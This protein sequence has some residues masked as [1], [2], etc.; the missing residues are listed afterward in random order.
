M[1][2]PVWT[3]LIALM[4]LG[5]WGA[6]TVHADLDAAVL[7]LAPSDLPASWTDVKTNAKVLAPSK[8]DGMLSGY[9]AEYVWNTATDPL[10]TFIISSS[11]AIYASP[12]GAFVNWAVDGS[13]YGATG[14]WLEVPDI[15]DHTMVYTSNTARL[16][17]QIDSYRIFWT[18]GRVSATVSIVK[19]GDVS[20]LDELLA[21]AGIVDAR[22]VQAA[23]PE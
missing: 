3:F 13:D 4:V 21:L 2:R 20:G 8:G 23:L 15:G 6:A 9:S 19:S 12:N 5:I 7:V 22:I 11:A 1:T 10:A 16:G 18:R 14:K 17:H